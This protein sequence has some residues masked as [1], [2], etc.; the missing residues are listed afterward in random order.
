MLA[1]AL[2]AAGGFAAPSVAAVSGGCEYR[3]VH[4]R[5]VLNVRELPRRGARV[6]ARLGPRTRARGSCG[7]VW[8]DGRTWV[9]L[10]V[11]GYAAAHYLDEI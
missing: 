11:P 10:D 9:R 4:V 1:A 5:T 6:V 8:S 2:A 7:R 3:V